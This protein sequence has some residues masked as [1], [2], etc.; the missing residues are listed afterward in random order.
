MDR[1]KWK[2]VKCVTQADVFIFETKL[3]IPMKRWCQDSSCIA[4]DWK[5]NIKNIAILAC[6][7]NIK[8]MC[9]HPFWRGDNFN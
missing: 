1:K 9:S 2:V 3:L 6:Q 4:E 5:T 7:L 8:I